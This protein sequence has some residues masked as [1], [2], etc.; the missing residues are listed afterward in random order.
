MQVDEKKIRQR[1]SKQRSFVVIDE[2]FF[3]SIALHLSL[4]SD[5]ETPTTAT[6]GESMFYNPDYIGKCPDSQI[7]FDVV[8]E[9]MHNALYHPWR[10]G[11]RDPRLWNV[12]CDYAI[13]DTMIQSGW[14]IPDATYLYDAR[15]HGM[16]SEAIYAILF[17]EKQE[18]DK[19]QKQQQQGSG[20]GSG[21]Q[22]QDGSGDP[23]AHCG[24]RDAA[25]EKADQTQAKMEVIVEAALMTA[26]AQGKLPAGLQLVA[27]RAMKKGQDWKTITRRFMQDN[28][29]ADYSW[30]RPNRRYVGSG[31]YIP[32]LRSPKL[33]PIG[34]FFD[35]SGSTRFVLPYFSAEFSA[36]V[37]ETQPERVIALYGDAK[38]QH[39]QEFESGEEITFEPK[40]GG[41]TD[42]R[43]FF[44]YI[45]KAGIHLACAF[46][47]TDLMGT[48]PDKAPDYP[49]LWVAT[50][51]PS[52]NWTPPFGEVV[53]INAQNVF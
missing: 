16:S 28:A 31:L 25:P 50:T 22:Q 46:V 19:K 21:K 17:K 20:S 1:V 37:A 29:A 30:S 33:G 4:I 13:H 32:A 35:T 52:G 51:E 18:R 12:A 9:I 44:E 27:E 47:M 2:F 53:Q 40:G 6:D 38:V 26:R 36:I 42:F 48:Y 23:K 43:P 15:F 41:G 24:M 14:K 11:T 49:V 10:R 5:P 7:K 45:E 34:V 8:H 39:V 3:G